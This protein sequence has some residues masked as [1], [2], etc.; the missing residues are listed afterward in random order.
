MSSEIAF[1]SSSSRSMRSMMDLSWSL[2]NFVAGSSSRTAAEV[3]ILVL[4]METGKN[5][6]TPASSPRVLVRPLGFGPL[7]FKAAS[8]SST[9]R[10]HLPTMRRRK[11]LCDAT[12][13]D[14][15]S[16]CR[17]G[18]SVPGMNLL[19]GVELLRRGR[20][21]VFRFPGLVRH[22]IDGFPALVLAQGDALG[23][24]GVLEPVGQ[25]V[26]AE[27]CEIHQV[28][29]LDVCPRLQMIDQAPESGSLEFRSGFVVDCHGWIPRLLR[30]LAVTWM[31]HPYEIR[32]GLSQILPY[33]GANGREAGFGQ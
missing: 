12:Q 21:L 10:P 29:V 6:V 15:T 31:G 26:A 3:A 14:R 23:V 1:F 20:A 5:E 25:A 33:R 13:G 17:R 24:G 2:A 28:D 32:W 22:A 9:A 16:G 18:R 7:G 11:L 27:A 30:K 8:R 4:P 19:H